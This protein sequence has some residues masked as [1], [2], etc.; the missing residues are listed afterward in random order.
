MNARVLLIAPID[1]SS[2]ACCL[3]VRMME[4]PGVHVAGVLLRRVTAQR[5]LAEWRRDGPRLLRKIWTNHVLRGRRQTVVGRA[6]TAR[7]QLDDRGLGGQGLTALCGKMGVPICRVDNLNG[8]EGLAFARACDPTLAI[9]AG[10]GMVRSPLLA[11]CGAGLLNCH[12]GPLPRY[13]GMDVVEWPFLEEREDAPAA[14][15]V[16]FMDN[17]LD[18]GPIIEVAGIPRD[19]CS[20]IADLRVVAEGVKV[21]AFLRAVEAHRDGRL[22][23][24]AQSLDAGRQYFVLHPELE[25]RARA[26]ASRVLAD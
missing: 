22:A 10:G 2:F 18:T 23:G 3:L 7:Q 4:A 17:G 25:Q 19:G 20:S 15:T 6:R 13:R 26:I 21:D 12:M 8:A 1:S 24:V 14:V 5:A 9:F 11:A 16:H